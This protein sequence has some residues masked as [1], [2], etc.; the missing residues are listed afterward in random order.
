MSHLHHT[1]Y[2][3]FTLHQR[4]ANIIHEPSPEVD[5]I[6]SASFQIIAFQFLSQHNLKF[7]HC[8]FHHPLHSSHTKELS[9]KLGQHSFSFNAN[10]LAS[11]IFPWVHLLLLPLYTNC[12]L[13][14]LK[15]GKYSGAPEN[16]GRRHVL[17]H[18]GRYCGYYLQR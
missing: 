4:S 10:R 14:R 9:F 13:A 12:P 1:T 5:S 7:L 16:C 11:N 17:L 8:C 6:T 18:L 3:S 15:I 2:T